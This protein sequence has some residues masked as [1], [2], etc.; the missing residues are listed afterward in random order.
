MKK[1]KQNGFT[2]IEGLLV[3]IALGVITGVGYYIYDTN[4]K[5]TKPVSANT[6]VEKKSANS[7]KDDAYAGWKTYTNK[8]Y[9]F[10]LKYPSDWIYKPEKQ[11][12]TDSE[13]QPVYSPETFSS[14]EG[15]QSASINVGTTEYK[16]AESA[17][18]NE[19]SGRG[20]DI[21]NTKSLTINGY[22]A[23]Y[24]ST[25]HMGGSFEVYT[26][27]HKNVLFDIQANIN[28]TDANTLKK[29]TESISFQ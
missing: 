27:L 6:Q 9:A 14:K 23:Y 8:Q 15:N 5:E 11:I 24:A 1:L 25:T 7:N 17:W 29:I 18:K 4:N 20:T 26:V 3:L 28:T 21:V 19:G 12:G 16:D 10:T 2:L 13:G 22:P